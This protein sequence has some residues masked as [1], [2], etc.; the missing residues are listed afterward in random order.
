MEQT[1]NITDKEEKDLQFIRETYYKLVEKNTD[2]VDMMMDLVR[3]SDS[4]RAYEVLSTLI[5]S[6]ADI[7][8]KLGSLHFAKKQAS[9]AL[10]SQNPQQNPQVTNNNIFVGS[11][12]DLQNM[13]NQIREEKVIAVN[14]E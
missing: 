1:T 8:E 2:A 14:G 13:L 5:R 6:A 3:D 11:T 4:P 7:S 10:T 12:A 9:K